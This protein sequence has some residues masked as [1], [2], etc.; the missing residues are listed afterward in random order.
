M[1][2]EQS[3]ELLV[4][5]RDS[6]LWVTI[7]REQRRNAITMTVV[8]GISAALD[9]AQEDR[10]VRAM[11]I[12]GAGNKAFCAGADLQGGNM[13]EIDASEPYGASALLFR[14]ARQVTVP[15]IARVNG[16]CVAGGMALMAMCDFV[17]ASDAAVFGLPEVKVGLFPAQVMALLQHLLPRRVVTEMCLTGDP[18]SA[19]NALSLGLVNAV[20]SDVDALLDALL[21]RLLGQSPAAIR[22]GLYMMKK[23]E[24]MSFE[25]SISFAESQIALFAMTQDAH[26]GQAAFR[27]KRKPKWTNL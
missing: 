7:N 17:V 22:R 10:S 18:I 15:L 21:M 23:M 9:W 1:N 13:F 11:V 14:K 5:L 24:S 3:G 19:N 25:E 26:E 12:T 27:E 2:T 4:D 16:A 20:G 8:Q 6:I